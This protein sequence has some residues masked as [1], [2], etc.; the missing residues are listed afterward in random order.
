MINFRKLPRILWRLMKMPRVFYALGLGP[1]MGRIVL[2]LTTR[3]R[4]TGLPR[5]TPLQYEEIDGLYYVASARGPKADWYLNILSDPGVEVRVKSKRF[6]ARAEPTTDA[7]R[8]ADFLE[9]RL[10]RHPKMMGNMLRSEG[11]PIKP[12]RDDLERFA[13]NSAMVIL[14]PHDPVV[15]RESKKSIA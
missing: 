2:L 10:E 12:G 13:E 5:V 4:K 1:L 11:L 6:Q 7:K 14:H 8:I 15:G 3:G 9:L